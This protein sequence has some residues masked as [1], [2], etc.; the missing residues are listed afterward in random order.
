M[1][2]TLYLLHY[3]HKSTKIPAVAWMKFVNSFNCQDTPTVDN[4]MIQQNMEVT[5]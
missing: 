3:R 1:I 5:A 4:G 2:L